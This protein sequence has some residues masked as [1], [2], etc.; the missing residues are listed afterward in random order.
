MLGYATQIKYIVYTEDCT[1]EFDNRADCL[2]YIN[3]LRKDG[4]VKDKDFLVFSKI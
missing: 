1:H 2:R 4:F 3:D